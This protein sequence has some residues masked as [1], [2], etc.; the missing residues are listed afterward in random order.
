LKNEGICGGLITFLTLAGHLG[1]MP[2]IL[3]IICATNAFTVASPVR[4]LAWPAQFEFL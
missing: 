1:P 4:L 3:I 2:G